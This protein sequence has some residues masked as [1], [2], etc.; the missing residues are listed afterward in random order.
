MF[1]ALLVRDKVTLISEVECADSKAVSPAEADAVCVKRLALPYKRVKPGANL[2]S[3]SLVFFG[4]ICRMSA[5]IV[6]RAFHVSSLMTHGPCAV[7]ER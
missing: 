7:L 6:C 2:H 4:V 5:V 3:F 1:W